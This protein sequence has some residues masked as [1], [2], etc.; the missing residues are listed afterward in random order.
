MPIPQ[1]MSPRLNSSVTKSPQIRNS[2]P[3]MVIWLCY[4]ALVK[5]ES[6]RRLDPV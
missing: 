1:P 2:E 6:P 5:K 4:R 3:V